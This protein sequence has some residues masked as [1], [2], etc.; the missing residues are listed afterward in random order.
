[1]V[2]ALTILMGNDPTVFAMAAAQVLR[3]RRYHHTAAGIERAVEKI[4]DNG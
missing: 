4:D 1:M 2:A 3:Q